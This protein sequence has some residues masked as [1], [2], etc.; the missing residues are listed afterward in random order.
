MTCSD[1]GGLCS[2]W[3]EDTSN[4]WKETNVGIP[5]FIKQHDT[6]PD[7][8]SVNENAGKRCS[9]LPP[10]IDPSHIWSSSEYS[11]ACIAKN[12]FQYLIRFGA[13]V[14][15]VEPSLSLLGYVHISMGEG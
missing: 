9:Q 7:V 14:E 5:L 13:S 15:S 3:P 1:V 4:L 8:S 6:I 10:N 2:C 11:N 12:L